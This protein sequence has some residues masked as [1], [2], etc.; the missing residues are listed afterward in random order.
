[1]DFDSILFFRAP[2]LGL[3]NVDRASQKLDRMLQNAVVVVKRKNASLYIV[4]N[5][6]LLKTGDH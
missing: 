4:Y 6:E 1:V 2:S 5:A 3:H